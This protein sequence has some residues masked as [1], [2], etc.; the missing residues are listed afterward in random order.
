MLALVLSAGL[1]LAAVE[2]DA[3][4]DLREAV[5]QVQRESNGKI[6]SARTVSTGR[7]RL[8]RIKILT[9]DGQVLVRTVPSQSDERKP[10]DP[11]KAPEED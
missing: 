6:L 8:H 7:K 4:D 1:A 10:A 2:G 9:E 11:P 3:V 5:A